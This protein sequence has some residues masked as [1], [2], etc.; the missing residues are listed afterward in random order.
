MDGSSPRDRLSAGETTT[1]GNFGLEARADPE[2]AG[3]DPRHIASGPDRDTPA[4]GFFA[5]DLDLFV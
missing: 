5:R 4:G 3:P 1:K 2:A